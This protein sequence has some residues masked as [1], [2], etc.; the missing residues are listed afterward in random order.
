MSAPVRRQ[1][2]LFGISDK[3]WRTLGARASAKGL[4]IS[5]LIGELIRSYNAGDLMNLAEFK[6]FL[7]KAIAQG[8]DLK[9][10]LRGLKHR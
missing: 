3:E 7:E 6:G 8:L 1:V 9:T 10:A 4:S 5:Q 2:S